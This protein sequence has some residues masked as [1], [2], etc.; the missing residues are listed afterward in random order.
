MWAE[1]AGCAFVMAIL[2]FI[3]FA[4]YATVDCAITM[5]VFT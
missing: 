5:C 3:L 1:L 2:S 4:A